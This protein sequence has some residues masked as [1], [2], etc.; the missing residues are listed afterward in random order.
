MEIVSVCA[1]WADEVH[2][3]V[4]KKYFIPWLQE[5]NSFLHS[6]GKLTR[7][8]IDGEI[9]RLI[10]LIPDTN[11]DVAEAWTPA[12]MT[13]VTTAELRKAWGNKITIFGGIP[14][15]LFESQY[16]D[17][18]FDNYITNLFRE[19]APGDNFIIGFG[20]NL[21]SAGKIERVG[22]VAELVK[23]YGKFPVSL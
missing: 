18:E 15:I 16:S 11:V 13:S 7:V 12:P 4:F 14:A 2:T 10:P 19:I 8:H 21:G 20:D 17:E 3:P 22:R 23:K 5:A 9:K 6:K 1:N